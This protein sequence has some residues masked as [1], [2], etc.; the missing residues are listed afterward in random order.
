MILP[1]ENP[2]GV[3][4]YFKTDTYNE[5]SAISRHVIGHRDVVPYSTPIR[6]IIEK[7]SIDKRTFLFLVDERRIVGLIALSNLGSGFL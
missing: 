6:T 2:N 5:F 7:F 1:I 3:R 4:E